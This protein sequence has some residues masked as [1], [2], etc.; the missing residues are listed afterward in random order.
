MRWFG[1]QLLKFR[2]IRTAIRDEA[3]PGRFR[4]DR[5]FRWGVWLLALGIITGWPLIAA[6]GAVAIYAREPAIV[7]V[8]GPV[9]YAISWLIYGA[10]LLLA[11]MAA[12][13]YMRDLNRFLMRRF[14]EWCLGG[15]P[16]ALAALAPYDPPESPP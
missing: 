15:R 11:G 14:A 8:G 9:S 3:S 5:R 4:P 6:L 1:R 16:A 13:H 2:G 12:V 7:A 10:G